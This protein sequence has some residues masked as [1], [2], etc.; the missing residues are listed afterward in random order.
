MVINIY[1]A[2]N[3]ELARHAV[4]VLRILG[5]IILVILGVVSFIRTI[6]Q[7]LIQRKWS[8]VLATV[9]VAV[10]S[11][12][13]FIFGGLP[14]VVWWP[15]TKLLKPFPKL[16][17]I[18]PLIGMIIIFVAIVIDISTLNRPLLVNDTG[19]KIILICSSDPI[20]LQ[21]NGTTSNLIFVENERSCTVL[22]RKENRVEENCLN[23]P[24]GEESKKTIYLKQHLSVGRCIH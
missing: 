8:P 2:S 1:N 16:R 18:V 10:L 15:L 23:F 4:V 20:E 19:H 14:Y 9:V 3:M 11:V 12:I 7:I 24:H 13:P 17:F 22:V 6:Y 5:T 21:P